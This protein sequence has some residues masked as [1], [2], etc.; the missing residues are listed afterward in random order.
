MAPPLRHRAEIPRFIFAD[1][2]NRLFSSFERIGVSRM[3]TSDL[4]TSVMYAKIGHVCT[5]IRERG[6]PDTFKKL[7]FYQIFRA[8]KCL[9][10]FK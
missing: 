8:I 7:T 3:Y 6:S 5:K 2:K 4:S 9:S 10:S 1:L